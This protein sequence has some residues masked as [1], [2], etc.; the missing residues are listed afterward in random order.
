MLR[1]AA[2]TGIAAVL[3]MAG[4]VAT[5]SA[6]SRADEETKGSPAAAVQEKA[7]RQCS[8]YGPGYVVVGVADL[9]AT[10]GA[11]AIA[12]AYK[13]F[14]DTDIALVGQR[15]PTPFSNG[16]GVPI[17]FY[18]IEDVKDD[19]RN[20]AFGLVASA[21]LLVRRDTDH[22]TFRSFVR[23]SLDGR[24]A[25][26]EDG[27]MLVGM[28]QIDES[29]YLGALDE[30]W[31]QINGLKVGLQ[32]SLFGF[33]RLPSTVTPGYTSIVTTAAI[34]YTHAFN[35]NASI[36][37]SAEDGGRR[38]F[39]DGVLARPVRSD[40]PDFLALMRFRTPSTLFHLSGALHHSD[41][42]VM[43]DFAGE[44]GERTVSGWAWSA[45]LQ[46]RINWS[47][48]FGPDAEG[49]YGRLGL[50]VAQASGA[51]HYLGIPLFAPDYVVGGDGTVS[52]SSGWSALASYEHMLAKNLKLSTNFS[53]FNVTMHS[54]PEAIIPALDPFS[55]ALPELDF[56]VNVKGSVLQVG[57]EYIPM[58]NWVVGIEG[59]Y[60]WTQAEGH[61]ADVEGSK[62]SV[63]F[64]HVGLYA[65]RTF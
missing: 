42:R 44:S 18:F 14:T 53:Y 26:D 49:K 62:V 28:K 25:Y 29:Y 30:A 65:R 39:G 36:S 13:E 45:G 12:Y 32:P 7:T 20:P 46:S 8:S 22:G 47:D 9:C 38:L 6:P 57:L 2:R 64:P 10:T 21:H 35:K 50:T 23:V 33:N 60:T 48:V 15:I 37:F 63:G 31:V 11:S 17:A 4:F 16:A 59:G 24:T 40:T 55:L 56:S 61:Y 3:V 34:S 51:L 19:T 54:L 5:T 27:N 43:A 58:R 52:R 1:A 41:D